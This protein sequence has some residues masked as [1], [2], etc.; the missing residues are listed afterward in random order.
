M[1]SKYTAVF[2]AP[3]VLL[4]LL[5]V[6]S[7]RPWLWRWQPWAAA[8]LALLA[9]TP[10]LLWNAA[11]G[12]VGLAKQAGRVGVW[13][14]ERALG[15]LFELI[16]GQVGFATPG[17]AVLCGAGLLLMLRRAWAGRG[18]F[19]LLTALTVPA[20]LVFLQH[21]L[22]DRVQANWPSILYPQAMLAAACLEG[23]WQRWRVPSA[24]LGFALTALVWVQAT[25]AP[26]PLPMRLDPTL[27]R[28]GGWDALAGEI[29][30]VAA[31]EHAGFVAS[32]NYGHAALLARLLPPGLA[33]LGAEGRWALFDLP[34]AH[35]LVAGQTG[36]LL[37]S[38]RRDDRPDAANWAEVTPIDTIDRARDG[39]VAEAF[40]LYRVT[41]RAIDQ[42]A[43]DP[44]VILPRP[45]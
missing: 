23:R 9:F 13:A 27:L 17:I 1:A 33:V 20:L 3:G 43:R 26:A 29:G 45:R 18:A 11:H 14:P 44:F 19:M 24:V 8:A 16:G 37:R 6:P 21:A 34:D 42:K 41:G 2:L 10:V 5:A 39:M 38:A 40:R 36:L 28:L 12:W 30:A 15:Y 7:L 4:W 35:A 22:G 32:D 31:R 25:A